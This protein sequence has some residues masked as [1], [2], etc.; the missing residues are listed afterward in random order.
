MF[1]DYRDNWWVFPGFELERLV[2]GLDLPVNLAFNPRVADDLDAPH[3]YVSE[4]YGQIKV[5][6]R[7]FKTLT[8]ATGLLNYEPNFKFPG[9]GESGVTGITV[10]PISGDLFISLIYEERGEVFAKVIRTFSVDGGLSMDSFST[11]IKAIPS[12]KAAHQI[13]AV[14]IGFDNKLYVNVGDGMIDP[15]VAQDEGELRGKILRMELDGSVPTDNP[16]A[17]NLIFAKGFRNP[18]GAAFRKSDGHLY[19]SDNGPHKDDRLAKVRAGE[20]YGWP[21]DMRKNSL[22]IWEFCQAPTA[23]AFA[24]NGE[25][26]SRYEDELFV[27]LFGAA[28]A[29]GRAVKGKKIVK[30]RLSKEA[31]A[32]VSYDTFVEYIGEGPASVC[33]LA[34]GPDG[35]YFTDLHGD[36]LG[37]PGKGRGSIY[38]IR[39]KFKT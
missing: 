14:T 38:R 36:N 1:E 35:L 21:E 3:I 25:F 10:E 23:I 7:G 13:Q 31:D 6:T 28:Y 12:V 11:I 26:P 15:S 5:V 9:T 22:F 2:T 29:Y 32:I 27:A 39:P 18:F 8:Y 16:K 37:G 33:G 17:D 20:N 24:Q 30:I 34:F 19:I 4:L